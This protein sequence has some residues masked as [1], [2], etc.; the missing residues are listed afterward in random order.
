MGGEEVQV[1]V[2]NYRKTTLYELEPDTEYNIFVRAYNNF[3]A[4]LNSPSVSVRTHIN[5]KVIKRNRECVFGYK[6]VCK[7]VY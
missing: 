1:V 6:C 5:G 4:S 2:G 7:C 3:G